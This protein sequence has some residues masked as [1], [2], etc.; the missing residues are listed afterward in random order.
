MIQKNKGNVCILPGYA[1]NLVKK[2][3]THHG[4]NVVATIKDSDIVVFLGGDDINPKLYQEQPNGAEAW[5]DARD[6]FEIAMYEEAGDRFKAGICRGGQLLNVLNGGS[7]WQDVNNHGSG[8]HMVTDFVTQEEVLLN[9]LHHQQMRPTDKAEV[10]AGCHLSTVKDGYA[11]Y[12]SKSP[13]SEDVD[14]EAAWYADTKSLCFQ[15]HPQLQID[16]PT[17]NYFMSLLERYYHAA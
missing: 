11:A 1:H 17:G 2:Y 7:L 8:V 15:P 5:D 16:G 3:F 13:G 10:I 9:S 4:Y 14:V 12:W 6:K